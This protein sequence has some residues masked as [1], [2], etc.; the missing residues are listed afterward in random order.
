VLAAA[1]ALMPPL[2]AIVTKEGANHVLSYEADRALVHMLGLKQLQ[3]AGGAASAPPQG[4]DADSAR[5]AAGDYARRTLRRR[6]E[7]EESD[8]EECA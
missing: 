4:L 2:I 5:F 7:E 8:D 6:A 3:E 1:R